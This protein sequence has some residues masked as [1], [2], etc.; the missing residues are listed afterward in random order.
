MPT[1]SYRCKDCGHEFDTVQKMADDALT[2]CP[3]C[4]HPSLFK[5]ITAAPVA[6]LG[7]GW[8]TN[9]SSTEEATFQGKEGQVTVMRDKK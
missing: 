2:D 1:Y 6:F 8:V 3:S 9:L 5:V 4:G 7:H